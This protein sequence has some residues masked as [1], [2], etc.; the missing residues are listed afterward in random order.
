MWKETVYGIYRYV[1]GIPLNGVEWA[2]DEKGGEILVF[3]F[4]RGAIKFLNSVGVHGNE[5]EIE[6]Q[7]LFIGKIEVGDY[8]E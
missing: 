4:K 2:L 1:N 3:A 8:D 7:G 5:K 6:E